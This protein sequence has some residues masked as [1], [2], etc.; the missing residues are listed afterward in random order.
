M[1]RMKL[2]RLTSGVK[3]RSPR[4]GRAPLRP[5]KSGTVYTPVELANAVVDALA[6]VP[7]LTWLEPC[8]GSGALLE[9]LNG[10]GVAPGWVTGVDLE[11]RR[12]KA[13]RF[14]RKIRRGKDFLTWA[15]KTRTKFDRIIA[16]P[17]Y[18][19]LSK[20]SPRLLDAALRVKDPDGNLVRKSANYWFAFLCASLGLLKPEGSLA[21]ILPAAWDYAD[22]AEPLRRRLV[23]LFR[24]VE[25]HRCLKPM[26]DQVSDGSIVLIAKGFGVSGRQ[27]VRY[28][29]DSLQHLVRK[30]PLTAAPPRIALSDS[31]RRRL[32]D[33]ISLKLGG[34]TGDARYFL[35]TETQRQ[36]REL[37]ETALVPVLSRARHIESGHIT[38]AHW[39]TLKGTG[40]R[41]WLFRPE[42]GVL[43]DL[44]VKDY[45]LYGENGGCNV[46]GFKIRERDPWYQT[47]MPLTVHGFMTGMSKHGI[48]CCLNEMP[49]L[50]ATNT[51]YV[52]AFKD[53]VTQEERAAWSLA[54]LTTPVQ[55]SLQGLGRLYPDGLRKFE[56]GDLLELKVPEPV[57]DQG[58]LDRYLEAVS[59]LMMGDADGAGRIA[60]GWFAHTKPGQST[61]GTG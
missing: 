36:L 41:V 56:P 18:V 38:R 22:Y 3:I 7:G 51:L 35:L 15:Q 37:P 6:P 8:I 4:M 27:L 26:F 61:R 59:K 14:C 54:L 9:A 12:R 1:R 57:R 28:E 48:W 10:A 19:A 52:V 34:V 33:V 44:A 32:G 23:D 31:G 43:D 17:P 55:R 2:G 39:E 40:H 42:E 11:K 5:P 21:F 45:R 49:G 29:Y 25:V 50:S 20:V 30:L 16:N 60:D 13:D 47:P 24:V 58:A 53:A 46:E